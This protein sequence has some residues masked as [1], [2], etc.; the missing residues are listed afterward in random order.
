[1]IDFSTLRR[2]ELKEYAADSEFEEYSSIVLDKKDNAFKIVTGSFHDKR[3]AYE[4]LSARGLICRKTFER[5]IFEWALRNAPNNLTAYL[6]FSTAFSK[7]KG[8]NILNEYYIKLLND[9]PA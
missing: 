3:D 4:K 2:I 9:I 7:W 1:M 5:R 8:N 6:M